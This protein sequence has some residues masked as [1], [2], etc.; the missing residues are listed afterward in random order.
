M[1]VVK[2]VAEENTRVE[3]TNKVTYHLEKTTNY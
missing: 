1:P 3:Q 2:D